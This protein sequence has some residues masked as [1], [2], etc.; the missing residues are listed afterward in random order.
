MAFKKPNK[1]NLKN[2]DE[3][4]KLCPNFESTEDIKIS[5]KTVY[6]SAV[7]NGYYHHYR[8]ETI[9]E[10]SK[11]LHKNVLQVFGVDDY[12]QNDTDEIIFFPPEKK[13]I[14][15]YRK[16]KPLKLSCE[17]TLTD[18]LMGSKDY[19]IIIRITTPTS[20]MSQRTGR[21]MEMLT[22]TLKFSGTLQVYKNLKDGKIILNKIK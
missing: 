15:I 2:L 14:R 11:N 9:A 5:D 4:T 16:E 22:A 19:P 8:Y 17:W 3:L 12:I 10:P 1:D 20:T 13:E 7:K 6:I 18:T 21:A